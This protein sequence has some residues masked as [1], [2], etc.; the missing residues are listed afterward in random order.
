G[1]AVRRHGRPAARRPRPAFPQGGRLQRRADR[2]VGRGL[3]R[4]P[5]EQQRFRGDLGRL[6]RARQPHAGRR[7]LGRADHRHRPRQ[8]AF[9]QPLAAA[10]L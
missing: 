2:P 8:R 4:R 5:R 9:Q 3:P 1:A 7:A 6:A 10:R